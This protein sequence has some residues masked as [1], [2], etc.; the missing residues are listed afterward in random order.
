MIKSVDI[1]IIIVNPLESAAQIIRELV[2]LGHGVGC[3]CSGVIYRMALSEILR[4][5]EN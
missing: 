2:V 4:S 3:I 1:V 5:W